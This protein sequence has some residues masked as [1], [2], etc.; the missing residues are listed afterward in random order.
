MEK[1]PQRFFLGTA[2]AC[3]LY[4]GLWLWGIA[5]VGLVATVVWFAILYDRLLPYLSLTFFGGMFLI[6]GG[7]AGVYIEEEPD[8]AER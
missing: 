3:M 5:I 1:K 4:A 2:A 6:L 8:G 7:L